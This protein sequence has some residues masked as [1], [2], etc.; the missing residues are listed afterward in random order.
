MS[1]GKSSPETTGNDSDINELQ[2]EL[3]KSNPELSDN[4]NESEDSLDD[5]SLSC[6]KSMSRTTLSGQSFKINSLP[7]WSIKCSGI[8]CRIKP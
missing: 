2:N 6:K 4:E 8:V 1:D 5:S 3:L 7:S